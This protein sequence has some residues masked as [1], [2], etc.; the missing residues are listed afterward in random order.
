M[1]HGITL[2]YFNSQHIVRYLAD[3]P[4]DWVDE[5]K[6][7]A[8]R[9]GYG[10]QAGVPPTPAV[11]EFLALLS[12]KHEL[13]TQREYLDWCYSQ[14]KGWWPT[15]PKL[16]DGLSVKLYR[17]FYPSMI[18]SLHAWALLVESGKFASCTIDSY[19]DAI[20]KT[21]ITVQTFTGDRF[22]LALR[23]DTPSSR[24]SAKYKEEHREGYEDIQALTIWL[25]CDKTRPKSPGQK[26][27]YQVSDFEVLFSQLG[28]GKVNQQALTLQ[29]RAN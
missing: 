18:D 25:P 17:N 1:R 3:H 11:E 19:A 7:Y 29:S 6:S 15:N 21:D 16:G 8:Q 20:A 9:G 27:W 2:L 23:V 26:R 12:T 14:W 22:S 5:Y 4:I 10:D 28:T 24:D 13:F